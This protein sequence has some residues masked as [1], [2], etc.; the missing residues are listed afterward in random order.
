MVLQEEPG[1]LIPDN[2]P[3]GVE[4]TLVA[5]GAGNVGSVEVALDIS[6]T[7]IGD[8]LVRLRSPAG[9]EAVLHN[10]EGE[11]ADNIARAYTTATTPPLAAFAGQPIAGN[12]TL[13]VSDH[14]AADVGKLNRW[15]VTIRPA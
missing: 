6:H 7:Y 14:E 15:S 11:A 3:V 10:R 12:W 2:A 5:S 4:R 8:L 13:K 9:T 1:T